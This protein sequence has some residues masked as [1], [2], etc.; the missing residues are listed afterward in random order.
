[1]AATTATLAPDGSLP[2]APGGRLSPFGRSPALR[3]IGRRLLLAIPVVWGTTLLTF[4]LMNLLP[5]TAAT[6]LL[7]DSATPQEVAL[8]NHKLGLDEP[9]LTRYLDWLGNALHGDLGTSL[10]SGQS[11]TGL[12]F[13]RLEVSAELIVLAFLIA[14]AAAVLVA[15]LAERCPGGISDR[16]SVTLRACRYRRS[17]S[18]SSSSSSSRSSSG[19]CRRS[20][21]WR[22]APTSAG[23]CAR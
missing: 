21:T 23:T 22:S 9:F 6:A 15:T 2:G 19:W 20:V 7:G 4:C 11:V 3:M 18:R 14:L 16:I 13:R 17:S 12:V 10:A 1:M 8:L 5:G